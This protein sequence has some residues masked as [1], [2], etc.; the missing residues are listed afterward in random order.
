MAPKA[1]R[2]KG[3]RGKGE[4]KKKE[5]KVVPSVI[6]VTVVTPYDSQVTLKGISTDRI[7]D[8]RKLLGSH[9]ETCHLTNY[10]LSHVVR[11]HRL[12]D[13]VE[14]VTLKP[15][16]LRIVEEDYSTE[17]QAIAHVRRLLDIVASTTVFGKHKDGVG[18][19][20][21]HNSSSPPTATT[22]TTATVNTAANG[23]SPRGSSSPVPGDP[24]SIPAISEK[25]DMA[26]IHPPP[27]LADFYDFFS[28]SHLTS[29]IQ[30]LRRREIDGRRRGGDY[31]EIEVKVCNGKIINVTSSAQG[32][33]TTGKQHVMRHS[34]V[35]LLQQLSSAFANAYESLMKA[36]VEHNKFGNL[37][38][39]FRANTW[40]VPPIFVES[41]SKCPS[42][43]IEDEN[44]GGNGGG[45]G[46][47]GKY[48]QRRWATEF[49]ILARMPCKTEEERLVRDRKAFLL[50]SLF[51]DTAIFKAVSAIHC[52]IDS[53]LK[54]TTS[55][56]IIHEE[57]TGDLCII[58]KRDPAD[59]SLKQDEK[60]DGS[61]LLNMCPKDVALR[62]LL[63]GLTADESAV[64][65]DTPTLGAVILKHCGYTA[66]VK[67]S[68]LIRSTKNDIQHIDVDDQPD[69]GSNALNINSLRIVLSK[70]SNMDR[71]E[72]NQC[73]SGCHTVSAIR[74]LVRRVLSDSLIKLE[75]E[76]STTDRSIRWELGA[77]WL[78][79]L[80]KKETPAAEEPKGKSEDPQVKS[81]VKGL[82]ENFEQLRK[83]K[84]RTDVYSRSEKEETV[85]SNILVT[86]APDLENLK[87]FESNEDTEVRKFLKEDAFSRLKDSETGLHQKSADELIK[88]AHKFYDDVA[89]PKLVADF[90]SLELSPV[91]GRTLTDFMHTR[92][93]NMSSLGHVVELAE[94]QPHIQSL[95]IHE[96][97]IRAFKYIIRAVVS[98]VENLSELSSAIAETLNILLGSSKE[99][100][101]N[102]DSLTEQTLMKKWV[103]N[104]ISK[105][106][107]WRI[108]DEFQHLRKFVI[109]R[110]LCNKVGLELVARDYDM[111]SPSP[112]E[113][114]DIISMVPVYKH[115]VCSSAD[116]RNLLE[117]SK[118]ALDKGKLDD[119]VSYGTKALSKLIAVCGP[120]NRMTANAYSLL[121][122]VLYHTGDFD[123]ATIYQQ[124]A[125]DINEREL[126]LDHPETMKSYG[127]LS[128]F[129]YRLQHIELALKYVNRALYLLQFSCGLSHP[130][131]AATY[132]NVAMMEE[133]MGNVHVALRYLHE[134]LKCNKRL[135]GA[136]H[137]QTAASYHAIAIA[138]SMMEAYSLSVQ[139]EQ[140]T[141]QILQ[142]K[143][144]SEDLRTQDAAAWLEYFE[145]KA[146]EQQEASRRGI[147]KPDSSIAS[148]GHLSV[149]DLL[150]YISPDQ[151][152]KER[153]AERKHRR[154]KN[155]SRSNQDES[156]RNVDDSQH[157]VESPNSQT[158][159]EKQTVAR[160]PEEPLQEKV[161]EINVLTTNELQQ[162][163]L[164]SPEE[165]S[166]EGW[167]EATL[168]G[169]S[170][171]TRRKFGWR[172]PDL[173]KLNIDSS[174]NTH[175]VSNSYKRKNASPALR[176]NIIE[177]R[178]PSNDSAPG[179]GLKVVYVTGEKDSNNLQTRTSDLYAKSE[180]S[181]KV[182]GSSRLTTIASKLISYKEVAVSPPGTVLK[183][184]LEQQE[185]SK[186]ENPDSEEVT[187]LPETSEDEE[188][189]V[190]EVE[191]D[192]EITSDDG[193]KEIH[194]SQVEMVSTMEKSPESNEN[195]QP[196]GPKKDT[197]NG[198]KLSASAPPFSP[199][200][201]LS[202]PHP[203]NTAAIYDMR[204]AHSTSPSQRMEITSPHSV[205]TRVPRG[206]RSTLYYRSG[207]TFRRKQGYSNSQNTVARSSPSPSIMNPHA[208]EFVPGKLW[209][210]PDDTNKDPD[211][212]NPVTNL[213]SEVNLPIL[214]KQVEADTVLTEQKRQDNKVSDGGKARE[215]KGKGGTQNSYKTELAR[216]ILLNFIVRS[217]HDSLDT[218]VETQEI[219]KQNGS[220]SKASREQSGNPLKNE[221]GDQASTDMHKGNKD[222]EGF[223]VVSKRRRSKQQFMS[224][225]SGL[226]SQQSIC[227]TVS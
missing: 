200:S 69:G 163:Y 34:L 3:N 131:S 77:C 12:T 55:R 128:V 108:K 199:G 181:M 213:S 223:T 179:K 59:A 58:I 148:K 51:V 123:Q 40:L 87:Q 129:Y 71:H 66:T 214:T 142:A 36:F 224:A 52:L 150:D 110:G 76:S 144:G 93:L 211:A 198:S 205:D 139:H 117:S 141:L 134:A 186:E 35:D 7:L 101:D 18:K 97:V 221:S 43:P 133:G 165:F 22:P 49:S 209:Q 100:N 227:T 39:G 75:K 197:T 23:R 208:A 1:G 176:G 54:L 210:Q 177:P 187:D 70:F 138:L 109:L 17:E 8:V 218:S 44:W 112:F 78:Q 161:K 120:Y 159:I 90:A 62:N 203:Y 207:H 215:S 130:N 99:E 48:D 106:F 201:L 151:D 105:R 72:G 98:A 183:P 145:S 194:S 89:L 9:V 79:D 103:E 222:T 149:S 119:A 107:S 191:L 92:G 166:D 127:D 212:Q 50:H 65:K 185:E 10:S 114:S 171:H 15:S 68:G 64:V 84:K 33:C 146:V 195:Q 115:K 168:K 202:M 31:F 153:Y 158:V 25:F 41:S 226:Y 102:Q 27:K 85:S 53:N 132:I 57:Q 83:I 156:I 29:P 11:G 19:S 188:K 28:F 88:M 216:Q 154:A 172:R 6:D 116:G 152:A 56:G 206:P 2:G 178:I 220:E 217:V 20:R 140:T 147:P 80:Q 45:H 13:G 175:Y 143:L 180:Q 47:D 16:V 74:N 137:I 67:V 189:K 169:R 60:V 104:F 124:K 38:Y 32:F 190:K 61:A 174:D 196:S 37:P 167:Q 184:I 81:V 5:E 24:E 63:K 162:A 193:E 122:V 164:I 170:G 26:A 14:I 73:L 94:K 225:V 30:F 118:T 219:T 86:V 91:D 4:K 95:C 135:L 42:L 125:L 204:V 155:N 126:G 21:K 182:S 173:A 96:M 160:I 136:D 111:N 121:A 82:G 46:R 157:D 113:K 192:K